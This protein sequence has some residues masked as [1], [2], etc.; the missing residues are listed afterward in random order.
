MIG[1]WWHQVEAENLTTVR[2]NLG[3]HFASEAVVPKSYPELSTR[4]MLVM[5]MLP[6]PKLVDGLRK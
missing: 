5:E 4:R 3:A 2:Q 1:G 6:G